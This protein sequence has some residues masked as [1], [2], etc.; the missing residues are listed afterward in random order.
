MTGKMLLGPTIHHVSRLRDHIERLDDG[1]VTAI[2][3]LAVVLRM[4]VCD[5]AGNN[6]LQRLTNA[7]RLSGIEIWVSA[8]ASAE[9]GRQL[10]LG[11]IP[12]TAAVAQLVGG[13]S[14]PLSKFL[15][16]RLY[17]VDGKVTYTWRKFLQEYAHKWGGAHLDPVIPGHLSV[18]DV[19]TVGVLLLSGYM[20]RSAAVVVWELAQ[21][22]FEAVQPEPDELR[23][24]GGGARPIYNAPGGVAGRPRSPTTLPHLLALRQ[25]HERADMTWLL[26]GRS[27]RF[28]GTL[29]LGGLN[30]DFV[31]FPLGAPQP[32]TPSEERP[33]T[34]GRHPAFPPPQLSEDKQLHIED[35]RF[36]GFDFD[37]AGEATGGASPIQGGV[38]ISSR[39]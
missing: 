11:S 28:C 39:A 5:G 31:Y 4:L 15:S 7:Y 21:A 20:L 6:L 22:I 29:R 8:E 27:E 14:V 24:L 35:C 16:S 37:D 26:D 33:P 10:T 32:V 25:D 3:D 34:R 38:A 12:T 1:A 17:L 30:R 2:D 13:R 18:L 36:I 23:A 9:A 19:H